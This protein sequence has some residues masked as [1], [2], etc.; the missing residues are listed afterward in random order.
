M[1]VRIGLMLLIIL[2]IGSIIGFSL[3]DSKNTDKQVEKLEVDYRY[4][5][6][7]QSENREDLI[8]IS[9]SEVNNSV[10]AGVTFTSPFRYGS[11]YTEIFF[12]I[13]QI[14]IY[15]TEAIDGK[16]SNAGLIPIDK[17]RSM[18]KLNG[19]YNDEA[20]IVSYEN[21]RPPIYMNVV[22]VKFI[23]PNEDFEDAVGLSNIYFY[24]GQAYGINIT[25]RDLNLVSEEN[26]AYLVNRLE[27]ILT[28]F[29]NFTPTN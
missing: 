5:Y 12:D 10:Q 14:E 4:D 18:V 21:M 6:S 28:N 3:Y 22:P 9:E 2:I 27:Y 29:G 8:D 25:I 7:Q 16:D 17:F 13:Y 20:F 19:D 11:E 23:I 26:Y 15:I 1:K 24:K